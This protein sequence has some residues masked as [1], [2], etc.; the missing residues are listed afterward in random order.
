LIEDWSPLSNLPLDVEPGMPVSGTVLD[1]ENQPVAGAQVQLSVTS[2]SSPRATGDGVPSTLA[3]TG[4]DGRFTVRAM[5]QG[6]RVTVEV[7]PP[8]A[9]GLPKLSATAAFDLGAPWQIHYSEDLRPSDLVGVQLQHNAVAVPDAQVTIVGSQVNAGTV[10]AGVSAMATG[11]VRIAAIADANGTLPRIRVPPAALSAVI[12]KADGDLAV[13]VLDTTAVL[14]ARI[15]VPAMQEMITLAQ[16]PG[17]SV[18]D[19]AVLDIVPVGALAMAAV[20]AVHL[21]ANK[22]GLLENRLAIGGRYELRFRDPVGRAAPLVVA[23]R[24][25]ASIASAYELPAA[26][27]LSGTL[28]LDG[29]QVLANAWVQILCN[30]GC[31]GLDRERPIAEA[32]SDN[33][34]RYVLAIPDPGVQ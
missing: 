9:S 11:E 12:R 31:R 15:D 10:T 4:A 18:L 27:K 21:V 1:P 5:A 17:A 24:E 3:T 29:T 6:S 33:V 23:E 8:A 2:A 32:I 26:I 19:G 7:T 28:R 20:P 25:V 34:G 14:P 16:G 30:D 22:A 13:V